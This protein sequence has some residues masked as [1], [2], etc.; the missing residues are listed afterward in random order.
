MNLSLSILLDQLRDLQYESYIPQE[1]A[2]TFSAAALLPRNFKLMRDDLIHVCRL[3]DAMQAAAVYPG[4]FYL[5]I[6][7]RIRDAAETEEL[8]Q[9]MIIVNE[10]MDVQLLFFMVQDIFIRINAWYQDMLNALIREESLQH[11]VNLSQTIIGNTINIFDSAFTLL[12]KTQDIETDDELSLLLTEFGYYPET[13]LQKFREQHRLEVYATAQDFIINDGHQLSSYVLVSKIFRFRNTYFTH[14]VM[15]CDHRPL[16]DGL[17]EL[18]RMLTDILAIYA[19]RNWKDKNSLSHNYDSFMSDLL[20]G[21]MAKTD[22][23]YERTRY[24]GLTWTGLLFF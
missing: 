13:T 22:D 21:T 10:N 19:E 7:D 15:V 1:C 12:A 17:L 8:L 9:N 18:F 5:C 6:R 20:N 24:L 3:S 23:I 4:K 11:I 16:T 14:V 2:Q